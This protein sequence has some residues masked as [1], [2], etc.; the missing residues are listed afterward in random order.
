MVRLNGGARVQKRLESDGNPLYNQK[1]IKKR[2]RQIDMRVMVIIKANKDS[3]AGMLPDEEFFAAM[4][5][6]NEELVKAGVMLAGEGLMPRS[7]GVRVKFAGGKQ[8]VTDGPFAE[9]RELIA[10]FWLWQV[11]SLEEAVEW[12]K[13]IPGPPKNAT[14]EEGEVE[15][16]QVF[17]GVDCGAGYTPEE[18]KEKVELLSSQIAQK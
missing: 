3:E 18:I 9:S 5:K 13:R 6:Y 10:G 7:K 17:D 15:I 14:E 2:R 4:T 12:V 16:R 11:N 1:P 8:I